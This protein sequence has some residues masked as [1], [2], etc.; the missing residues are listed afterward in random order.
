MLHGDVQDRHITLD[1]KG[2]VR[3][4]DW[5]AGEKLDE[6]HPVDIMARIAI[7]AEEKDVIRLLLGDL[8]ERGR[9][10]GSDSDP[11]EI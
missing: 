10:S 3:I 4:I 6:S 1:S 7:T 8:G 2:R 11:C 5:E 9:E